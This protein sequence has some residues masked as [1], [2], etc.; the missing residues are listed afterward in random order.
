MNAR[1][2]WSRISVSPFL[3]SATA[4]DSST[5][6][7]R[8]KRRIRKRSM[9]RRPT[10]V[11]TESVDRA[12]R[13]RESRDSARGSPRVRAKRVDGGERR[14][15]EA[16]R[17][18]AHPRARARGARRRLRDGVAP[19]APA[20]SGVADWR[21]APAHSPRALGVTARHAVR[22]PVAATH[23]RGRPGGRS[24]PPTEESSP[25][26]PARVTVRPLAGCSGAALCIFFTKQRK[27]SSD[28]RS[29]NSFGSISDLKLDHVEVHPS[30]R[31]SVPSARQQRHGRK[32]SVSARARSECD[33]ARARRP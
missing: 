11:H 16:P 28:A 22:V 15:G 3:S 4:I 30:T 25:G 17:T 27:V 19:G 23:R 33:V 12:V 5:T 24:T 18:F 7:N 8:Q 2:R 6:M 31:T 26:V 14:R 32:A 21:D 13:A 29:G 10:R 20:R 9:I 1:S